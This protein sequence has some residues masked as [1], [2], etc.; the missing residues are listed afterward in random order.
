[1]ELWTLSA[2]S[3]ASGRRLGP[4]KLVEVL[5]EKEGWTCCSFRKK[6]RSAHPR[7]FTGPSSRLLLASRSGGEI[8]PRGSIAPV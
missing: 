7:C 4:G 6:L 8:S 3:R 2:S 1:M 5:L